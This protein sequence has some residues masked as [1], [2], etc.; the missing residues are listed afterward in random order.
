MIMDL[1]VDVVICSIAINLPIFSLIAVLS[2]ISLNRAWLFWED[3]PYFEVNKP[4]FD[5][6]P[7]SISSCLLRCNFMKSSWSLL[8]FV[9]AFTSSVWIRLIDFK[10]LISNSGCEEL[11]CSRLY[12]SLISLFQ[13]L[14]IPRLVNVFNSLKERYLSRSI[15]QRKLIY[16]LI[17]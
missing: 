13:I 17:E 7:T 12:L 3:R 15:P 16:S 9:L 11:I 10:F 1:Q 2:V 8:C 14:L 4:L 5:A 6:F